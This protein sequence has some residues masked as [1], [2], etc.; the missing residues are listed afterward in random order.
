M[1]KQCHLCNEFNKKTSD[2][3][4]WTLLYRKSQFLGI[5]EGLEQVWFC[6]SCICDIREASLSDSILLGENSE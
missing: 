1:D 2:L 3:Y 4:K 5:D 6:P